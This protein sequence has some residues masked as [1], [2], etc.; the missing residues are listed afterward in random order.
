VDGD[1]AFTENDLKVFSRNLASPLVK[2]NFRAFDFNNDGV[3]D[4]NDLAALQKLIQGRS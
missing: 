1:G 2:A 4:E 3:V